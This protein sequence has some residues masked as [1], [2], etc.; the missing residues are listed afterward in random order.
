MTPSILSEPAPALSSEISDPVIEV[1]DLTKVYGGHEAVRGVTFSVGRGEILG[2]LGPNGAGKSTTMRILACYTPATSGRAAI[3]GFDVASQSFEA[4]RKLGYLPENATLYLNMRVRGFLRFMAGIKGI[5]RTEKNAAIGRAIE[6][7]DLG[8]VANR[9]IANLSK[10]FRQ[11]VGLAQA[12]LGDPAVL[13][14]DEPT[15]GL[16]PRQIASIRDLIRRMAGHRTVLLSTHILPEVS[17]ICQ[18]VVVID[19]GRIVATGTPQKLT[20]ASRIEEP[21][22]HISLRGAAAGAAEVMGRVEGVAEVVRMEAPS[23]DCSMY[24]VRIGENADPRGALARALVEGNYELLEMTTAG[25]SLE[26]VFLRVISRPH[27]SGEEL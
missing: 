27:A 19:R 7:C 3:A 13:I 24:A 21:P 8:E 6:E 9:P 5:P 2:F 20:T 14:L 16:D 26:D 22:L 10:G 18:R 25:V 1:E 12:I 15:V 4:R 23:A 17:M 11:R